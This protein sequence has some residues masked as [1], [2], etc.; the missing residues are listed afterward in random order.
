MVRNYKISSFFC[1]LLD[2]FIFHKY[3]EKIKFLKTTGMVLHAF[4]LSTQVAEVDFSEFKSSMGY[5]VGLGPCCSITEI[6]HSTKSTLHQFVSI[7]Q[8]PLVI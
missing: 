2:S 8:F 6:K 3:F 5:I 7:V 1:S 4:N